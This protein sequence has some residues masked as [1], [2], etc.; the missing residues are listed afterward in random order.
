MTL[1]LKPLRGMHDLIGEPAQRHRHLVNTLNDIAG[2]YGCV[3]IATPIVESQEVF[4]RTLGESSDV[5]SK[6]MYTLEDRKGTP[7]VLRPEGTAGIARAFISNKLHDQ[8]PLRFWY[9]GPMFRYERPQKGRQRQF[10]QVGVEVLGDATP[11]LEA[12]MIACAAQYL[13]TLGITGYTLE[14]NTLG[15]MESRVNFRKSLV[16]YLQQHEPALSQDSKLRLRQNPLRILDSK[17]AGD[18]SILADAPAL[19]GYL[20]ES[21]QH[22][23][24]ALQEYLVA[25]DVPFRINEKIVRGLDYYSHT[26]FEFVSNDLGAQG[27]ILAGGR[28]DGLI[29]QLGGN[30]TP[31]F[32]WAAG[33]ERLE[34]LLPATEQQQPLTAVLAMEPEALSPALQMANRLR[35]KQ[36]A[37]VQVFAGGNPGKLLKKA[38]KQGA[39]T[40]MLLGSKE[41]A[42][43][44]VTVKDLQT[45]EQQTKLLDDV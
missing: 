30:P 4:K 23:F 18:Q 29:E 24:N 45:G 8:L 36:Q 11:L 17:D 42:D 1:S 28:Y 7:L 22:H 33:I 2:R 26:V 10:H 38:S 31:G 41:L 40:A 12:E 16:G 5:V 43:G 21:A 3:E 37:A 27:T 39:T 20:T 14:L 32:G 35:E 34:M 6:E 19:S 25:L 15:D 44:T 13:N 9:T